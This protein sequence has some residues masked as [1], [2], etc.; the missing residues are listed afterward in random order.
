MPVNVTQLAGG[1]G[2]TDAIRFNP[3]GWTSQAGHRYDV[4]VTGVTPAIDYQVNMVACQ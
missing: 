4:S 3:Q 2:S 1:Y